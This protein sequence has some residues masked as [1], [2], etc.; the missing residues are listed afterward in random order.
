MIKKIPAAEKARLRKK[1]AI[2]GI[3]NSTLFPEPDNF[4]QG[5]KECFLGE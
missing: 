2:M 5:L 3:N 4:F 1:L